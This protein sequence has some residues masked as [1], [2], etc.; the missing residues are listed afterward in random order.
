MSACRWLKFREARVDAVSH[1][2]QIKPDARSLTETHE[3]LLQPRCAGDR[4]RTE[5][6]GIMPRGFELSRTPG[7]E[8]T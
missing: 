7:R 8:P 4:Y 5:I 2:S 6:I 1:E 3:Q